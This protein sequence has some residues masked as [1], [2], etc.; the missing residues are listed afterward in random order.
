MSAA[1]RAAFTLVLVGCGSGELTGNPGSG[2]TGPGS[3]SGG[4]GAGAGGASGTGGTGP[5]TGTGCDAICTAPQ[6]IAIGCEKRF[7]YGVNYAWNRF[8][9]D[10]GGTQG[11]SSNRTAVMN[12]LSDMR[13]NGADTVRWWVWPNLNAGN[14]VL[15]GNGTPTGLGAT[16]LPD[17]DAALGMAAQI[18]LHIQFTLFSFDNFRPDTN[19]IRSIRPIVVDAAK[20]AALMT[21]AVQPFV[22]AVTTSANASV[23]V[24]WDVIN[25]PEWAIAGSD[26]Y[27]DPAYTPQTNLQTVTQAEMEAL[28]AD[29]I[30]AIRAESNL[31][32]TV[33]GSAAKWARAWSRVNVDYY[34]IHIYDW[35]NTGGWPYDR[36]PAQLGLTAK[37]VVMGEFPLGGLTGVSYAT[38]VDSWFRNGYAGAM[39]WSVTDR[40]F[41]W[42]GNKA[43]VKTFAD[44]MGCVVRY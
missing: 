14:V 20:R 23:S 25:E 36:S 1:A 27:G 39:G 28:V 12:Q 16:V 34:T 42:A 44:A 41:N 4:N 26:G 6:G 40:A 21:A 38:M 15:D 9:G 5:A 32:I 19:N 13:A 10:F 7:F 33:G 37:P 3:G 11:V 8:A 30:S 2:G 43:N 17:L 31:P 35:V 29:T 22:H 18:G 24:G